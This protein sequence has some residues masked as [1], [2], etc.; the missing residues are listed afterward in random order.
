MAK[1]MKIL[2]WIFSPFFL[3]SAIAALIS[4]YSLLYYE[5]VNDPKSLDNHPILEEIL[6]LHNLTLDFRMRRRGFRS[7]SP[8]IA[9][10]TIDEK[11]IQKYGRWPWPRSLMS[12][13]IEGVMQGGAKSISFDII[14]SEKQDALLKS[15]D[16]VRQSYKKRSLNPA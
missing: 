10:L 9:V 2:N 6:N 4:Y 3:G 1:A 8:D 5:S 13:L 12:E 11:A 16:K 15:L 7:G 14:F